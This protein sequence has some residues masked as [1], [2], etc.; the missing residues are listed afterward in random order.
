MKHSAVSQL[1]ARFTTGPGRGRGRDA[2]QP[3]SSNRRGVVD[4]LRWS[5]IPYWCEDPGAAASREL[6]TARDLGWFRLGDVK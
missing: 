3:Q 1:V 5:L 6:A 2:E 4:P